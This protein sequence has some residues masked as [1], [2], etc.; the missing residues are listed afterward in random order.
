MARPGRVTA[1]GAGAALTAALVVTLT[2]SGGSEARWRDST[3]TTA[4]G[5]TS[6]GFGMTATNVADNAATPWPSG[7]MATSLQV[8]LTNQ[9]TRHS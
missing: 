3:A 1:L 7:R 5:A 8:N 2:P 4:T 6:D 9:A